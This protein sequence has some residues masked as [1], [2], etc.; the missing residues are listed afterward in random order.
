MEEDMT[1]GRGAATT[2]TIIIVI[3]IVTTGTIKIGTDTVTTIIDT[4]MATITTTL[5]SKRTGVGT[6]TTRKDTLLR[7][8]TANLGTTTQA[9]KRRNDFLLI[10]I[11]K[12]RLIETREGRLTNSTIY[13][14]LSS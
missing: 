10:T 7:I 14:D 1:I 9:S 4:S 12:S 11:F 2:S 6:R 8:F 3:T 5:G 13:L